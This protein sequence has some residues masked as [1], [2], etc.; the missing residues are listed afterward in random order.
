MAAI[1]RI[2]SSDLVFAALSVVPIDDFGP[3]TPLIDALLDGNSVLSVSVVSATATR[4]V[5]RNSSTDVT[6]TYFG[7]DRLIGGTGHDQFY[8]SGLVADGLD[9]MLDYFGTAGDKQTC[10]MLH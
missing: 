1:L 6:T 3:G 4:I 10:D 7:S 8:H 2:D 9:W 5:L